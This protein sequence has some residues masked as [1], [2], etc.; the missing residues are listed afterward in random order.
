MKTNPAP[1]RA[2][3]NLAG[4]TA[5]FLFG[6]ITWSA[7]PWLAWTGKK[8]SSFG[9]HLSHQRR[10]YAL[11]ATAFAVVG[12]GTWQYLRWKEA[13]KPRPVVY[14]TIQKVDVTWDLPGVQTTGIAEKDLVPRPLTI[15]FS[16]PSAPMDKVGK[17]PGPGIAI[18]PPLAGKWLWSDSQT[19]VFTPEALHLQPGADYT[20]TL[21]D[22]ELAPK[23]DFSK[24]KIDFPTSPLIADLCDFAFYT[25][26]KDTSLHQVV[27]ELRFSHPVALDEATRHLS[28]EVIGGTQL[29]KNLGQGEQPFT[30]TEGN[31]PR[32]YFIRSRGISIPPKEDFVK[33]R[34]TKGVN[35][36]AWGK[37]L[38]IDSELKTRVPDKFS[39]FTLLNA[40][41]ELIRND[42]GEPEQILFVTSSIELD[43]RE[44]AKHLTVWWHHDGFRQGERDLLE[45]DI[46]A[47]TK[48]ELT[49]L[50]SEAPLTTRHA[51]R[52]TEPR[53]G[54]LL[55]RVEPG[56]KAP[57]DFELGKRFQGETSVPPFP[58]E[59]AILGK[60]NIL[61]LGGARKLLASSRGMQ[62]LQVSIGRVPVSQIQHLVSQNNSNFEEPDFWGNFDEDNLVQQYRKIVT[63]PS[64]KEWES[65]QTEIDLGE[66]PPMTSP[67]QLTG[68]RGIFFVAVEPVKKAE[69]AKPDTSVYGRIESPRDEEWSEA[70][71]DED[72]GSF[73]EGWQ[74]G[75]GEKASRFIMVTD[76]GLM[77]KAGA[78]ESRDIFV[79]SLTNGGPIEGVSLK[80][81]ARNGTVLVEAT[82][83][84]QGRAQFPPLSGFTKE[85]QAV[86]VL[87]SK[88]DDVTFLPLRE[89]QLPAMDYS[90]FDIGGVVASRQK[91][92]EG[93][94]FT[95]RGVYRPGDTVNTGALVRRRD[96]EPV[97]EGLPVRLSLTDSKGR[98]VGEQR[99][100]M[101][102]D[103][104][105]ETKFP[106]PE[107]AP[108]GSYELQ[109]HVLNGKDEIMFRL[110]RAQVKVEEFQPDRSKVDTKIDPAPPAGWMKPESTIARAEVH[111]LFGDAAAERR[112]TMKL[113]LS[114][115]DFHF[116]EWEGFTFHDR[117]AERSDSRA[118]RTIDL[119]EGKTDADGRVEFK[120]P[121][122]TLTD[123][124][125]RMAVTTEAFERESGRS[126]RHSFTQMVSP[127]EHVLGWK[128][129][130][131]LDYIGKD[132]G[133][134]VRV[135]AIDRTLKA[136]ELKKLHTRLIEIRQVSALSQL[137][138]GNYA[139]VS[140]RHERVAAMADLT[141]A[142]G[143]S[144]LTL[145]TTDAGNFRLEIIDDGD[146]VLCVIPYRIAG[147]GDENRSLEREAELELVLN[148][149]ELNPGD[150][151][152][153]HLTAP[154]AGAGV[155][156]L[157][158]DRV[159][160][161]QWFKT[162]TNQTTVK[163]RVP[164]NVEGTVYV[165]ASFVRSPS[166]P[167]VFHSPL[168]YAA[169]PLRII[170]VRRQMEVKLDAP[171]VIRPGT[172]VNFGYS[173]SQESRLVLYAVD[174]GIHRITNYKLPKPVDYFTRKQA[175][176]VRTLQWLDLLLP[177]YQFLKTAPAFGGDGDAD[178]LA[179]HVNPFKR[180]QEAPV[181]FWS[182]LVA[183]GPERKEVSW[184]VPDY[185]NGNVKIM[186]VSANAGS[187]GVAETSAL[188]KAPI[189]LVPNAP[190]FVSPGDEF[191]SSLTVTNN[192]DSG[193]KATISVDSAST[194]HLETV[195][196]AVAS[197]ELEPGK[198][199]VL[200]F[201]F[202]A[203]EEL[204]AAEL[205]FK[206][207]AGSETI[208]RS[209]PL[210]VRPATH[211]LT[212]VQSGWFRTGSQEVET[213]RSLFP[214]FRRA[215]AVGSVLPLGLARGLEAYVSGFPHGCSEQITSRAMVKLLVSTEADFGLP[216][217]VAAEHIRGAISQL[218]NRQQADGG[219]GYW[220]AGAPRGF[221]FPSLY[222]LHFLTEA[223]LLGHAVPET[224]LNSALNYARVT[225]R[226]EINNESQAEM[227]AYAI[228]LLARNGEDMPLLLNLRDTLNKWPEER[229][230]SRPTAA[231]MA[232]S[233]R[234]LKSDKEAK[235]LMKRCVEARSKAAPNDGDCYYNSKQADAL[236]IFYVRCRHFQ[237]QAKDF[238]YDDLEPIMT[239][240]RDESF[241]TLTASFM[242]MALK[243]Y[244]D[245]AAQS[246]LE[247]SIRSKP[248]GGSETDLVSPFIGLVRGDFPEGTGELTF[249]RNQKGSGDIGAFYQVVEQ[250]Y[251]RG[252]APPAQTSGIGIFREIKKAP[253]EK[254]LRAGDAVDVKLTVRNLTARQLNDLAV[255]DL[256][257]AG[258]EIVAG[259]LKSGPGAVAG[260]SF[261]EVR[262]DRSLF[263]LALG[264]NQEW[265][266]TYRMKATCPGSFSVPS[267]LVE[268]MYDRGR[269]GLSAPSRI[270]VVSAN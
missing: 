70:D 21:A 159:L 158:R 9:R 99:L 163:L 4:R 41:A 51:F 263:Y 71:D 227:Q 44:V 56:V 193:E 117:S 222:V 84:A 7:P 208:S 258:F 77:V 268:D 55:V 149:G 48:I 76:L 219:F 170:P 19:L 152:E 12:L 202:R 131:D 231:W 52:F 87:A 169:E 245:V 118:G 115:A 125:Y 138:N 116:E 112:V 127:W 34:L 207:S 86:A 61:T 124:S 122:E 196:E 1:L 195:G 113:D 226:A 27:G 201:R 110:G 59:V 216:P 29:F 190:L 63:L 150:E 238:V 49:P 38:E 23:L 241:T 186:A 43:S 249:R 85:R 191:V 250:G 64:R 11:G 176:E 101:P 257:P 204:G 18:Q 236:K 192:L 62:H 81:L 50:A 239:P 134:A 109:A 83:D 144:D 6:N 197:I 111:S 175:L 189:I 95:E 10:R 206:A 102:Y 187:I 79:M 220:Y 154:Y 14:E 198:E 232:A 24:T 259:D 3:R 246:K 228:Y 80:A 209:M 30:V 66:S 36:L 136:A 107:T 269:H 120:L 68:G 153:V 146:A 40:S 92:V 177:E 256:L 237:E 233:Y 254:P 72:S 164:E 58:K 108:L 94:L 133:R 39:R 135:V 42:D 218:A 194:S 45:K 162:G 90:R 210:S 267:A 65:T 243:A 184:K 96:W 8:T 247:L 78:D 54:S 53:Y 178:L 93:F 91:A 37:P 98:T 215:E 114:P 16:L 199:G 15:R 33:L 139:Y 25:S 181:V 130:G 89:R 252:T 26:P 173:A 230:V 156:T 75:E 105:L 119:G 137:R 182:G 166:S 260:T 205:K 35:A 211:F 47:A 225:A 183:A 151:V 168:S 167:E 261:S 145:N 161:H 262:E 31:G 73:V 129:D 180:R 69:P 132:A 106:V 179:L 188:V 28:L 251:D 264:G 185:F 171:K 235:A 5:G 172:E 100:R 97:L 200:F 255:I 103:G 270:E 141:L 155:V 147:K 148:K 160:A 88:G 212:K 82:T 244:G 214:Q 143:G 266:V 46:A 174:E 223:K 104:F 217:A 234:L 2:L 17:E 74:A 126:V 20:V 157:E 142:A 22:D 67:D 140:T 221:D 203:K 121:L 128:A 123:A 213:K 265:S 240:L 229:W 32:Q 57:G 253:G 224:M 60:G 242:T 165:N 13:H 248:R